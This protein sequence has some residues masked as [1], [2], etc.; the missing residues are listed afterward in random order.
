MT[1]GTVRVIIAYIVQ[2]YLDDICNI[3]SL[4]LEYTCSVRSKKIITHPVIQF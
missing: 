4:G 2:I 1:A 3:D